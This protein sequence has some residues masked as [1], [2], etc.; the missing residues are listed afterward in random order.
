M[1]DTTV[2]PRKSTSGF[3]RNSPQAG[4]NARV[5]SPHPTLNVKM[6]GNGPQLENPQAYGT[7]AQAQEPRPAQGYQ[8]PS[9]R[10]V[11]GPA[12][13]SRPPVRQGHN[14]GALPLI[15]VKMTTS[16]PQVQS[17][18]NDVH[19]PRQWSA[20]TAAAVA[21]PQ[22]DLSADQLLL[23]RHAVT[24][25]L[26][27]GKDIPEI[28][29]GGLTNEMVQLAESTIVAI[30]AAMLAMTE[31][32]ALAA[33][34]VPAQPQVPAARPLPRVVTPNTVIA[35][36]R[37]GQVQSAAPRRV[38]RPVQAQASQPRPMVPPVPADVID[39]NGEVIPA[40][41]EAAMGG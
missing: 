25:Y 10:A 24:D 8:M 40:P 22:A 36:R 39:V 7:Q 14:A 37:S 30:D 38:P 16:G 27:A 3:V 32:E 11:R 20:A 35:N 23:C 12:Q 28:E 1:A 33:V 34:E 19:T 9:T 17:G 31:A 15:D 18:R 29:P 41:V 4:N 5:G 13:A 2:L 6:T 21:P 26:A